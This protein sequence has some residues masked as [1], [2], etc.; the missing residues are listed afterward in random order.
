MCFSEI[1]SIEKSKAVNGT[2]FSTEIVIQRDQI[3]HYYFSKS[4]NQHLLKRTKWVSDIFR[5]AKE[6]KVL[7]KL[8]KGPFRKYVTH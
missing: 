5:L 3:S 4:L 7:M 2:Q 8:F 6:N 1:S